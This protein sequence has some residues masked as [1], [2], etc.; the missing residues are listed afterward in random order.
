MLLPAN[1]SFV[2]TNSLFI[3]EGGE[4]DSFGNVQKLSDR[5]IVKAGGLR[6]S[7]LMMLEQGFSEILQFRCKRNRTQPTGN[8][9]RIRLVK[10]RNQ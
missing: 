7:D 5:A 4:T 1:M 8:P 9:N 6:L 10:S 2:F 3:Y